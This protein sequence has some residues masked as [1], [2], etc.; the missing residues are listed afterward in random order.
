[1]KDVS[2]VSNFVKF[3]T[4]MLVIS[5]L[6]LCLH[7]GCYYKD[8]IELKKQFYSCC[9]KHADLDY[10]NVLD[11]VLSKKNNLVPHKDLEIES[12]IDTIQ[13]LLNYHLAQKSH[14][15]D[16]VDIIIDKNSHWVGLWIGILSVIVTLYTILQMYT[17]YRSISETKKEITDIINQTNFIKSITLLNNSAYAICNHSEL[18]YFIPENQRN[19]IIT[20]SLYSLYNSFTA[21]TGSINKIET[22]TNEQELII[23]Q[24]IYNTMIALS[25]IEI[26]FVNIEV[27]I[28]YNFIKQIV[29]RMYEVND[30]SDTKKICKEMNE[31]KKEMLSLVNVLVRSN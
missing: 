5:I 17:N 1:M 2:S 13:A 8:D 10:Y 3:V 9:V 22:I 26:L 7:F 12:R 27:Y 23:Q 20:N 24:C 30:F 21:C 25:K 16:E 19:D 14:I 31:I 4:I 29:T 18:S 6:V 15:Q 28:H 11:S